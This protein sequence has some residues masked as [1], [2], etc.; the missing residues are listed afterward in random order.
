MVCERPRKARGS[1]TTIHWV[2]SHVDDE[3]RAK[4]TNSKSK[5]TCACREE[6]QEVCDPDHRHHK[7]NAEADT[8][9]GA[10]A[11]KEGADDVV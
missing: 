7:G 8:R 1:Q 4:N 11:K 9:A 3:E 6:G 2:H 10:G 5:L